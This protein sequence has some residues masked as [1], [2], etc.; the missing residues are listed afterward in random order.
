MAA[1]SRM[2]PAHWIVLILAAAPA[3][4]LAE[5]L[6]RP[7]PRVISASVRTAGL[8]LFR[9][10]W[11]PGDPLARG[12]GLGPVFN[13]RSCVECHNQGGAGGGGPV[14]NNVTVYG[15][16]TADTRGLP[17]AGVVHQNAVTPR[18][19]ET[20]NLVSPTL[21]HAPSLPLVVLVDRKRASLT[22]VVITQRNTP[23]L[24]GD[25]L[26]DAIPDEV[27]VAQEREHSTAA[28]LVGLNSAHDGKVHGRVARLADGRIGR[29]GWKLEFATLNDFVK[30]ACA[31]ELGLASPNQPQATPL[32]QLGYKQKGIDLT[33]EQCGLMADFIRAL[34]APGETL[35]SDR[36]TTAQARAGREQFRTIGCTDCHVETLGPAVGIYSDLLLHDM[37]I[38]LEASSGYRQ[39]DCNGVTP[40]APAIPNDRFS[41]SQ[42]PTPAEWRTAPLWGVADSA[43][44]L[45]DGRASTLE[46]AIEQHAGEA[47]STAARFNALPP[48]QRAAVI[49]FLKTLRA[50]S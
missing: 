25:G 16:A 41:A 50:P 19:Q 27:L 30:A 20:L 3:W 18:L 22:D 12:D 49:A 32:G 45:H 36:A 13:A 28:R 4:K 17:R 31:N 39:T 21:P 23:A 15:L 33:D 11:T 6:S 26:I 29:F 8:E 38:E 48:E 47:A 14:A 46:E 5:R 7:G 44:Y 42:Q 35:P 2:R 34:P 9:H 37:G 40:P 1:R 43:P 10:E 24:F